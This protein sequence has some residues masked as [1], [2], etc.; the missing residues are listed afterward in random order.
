MMINCPFN[1][2]FYRKDYNI[3]I[4]HPK[5]ELTADKVNDI[6]ICRECILNTGLTQINRFHNLIDITSVN[7]GFDEV[8]KICD[9]ESMVR[10][11]SQPIKACYLVPNSLLYGTIRMYDALIESC[12]VEVHVSYDINELSSVL[13]VEKSVL[14]SEQQH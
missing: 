11:S 8:L 12:G 7:L 3:L 10:D 9:T 5:G 13:G 14:T 1:F 6:A 2:G 4:C